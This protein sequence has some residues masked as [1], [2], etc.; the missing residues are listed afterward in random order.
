MNNNASSAMHLLNSSLGNDVNDIFRVDAGPSHDDDFPLS[1]S[2]QF[3]DEG[4]PFMCRA[5]LSACQN[6][7]ESCNNNNN[8]IRKFE[9]NKECYK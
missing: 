9:K 4:N 1:R 5:C 3:L 6:S 7:G 8:Y 2:H